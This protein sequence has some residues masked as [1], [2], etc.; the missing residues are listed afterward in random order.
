ML[1]VTEHPLDDRERVVIAVNLSPM[2]LRETLRLQ[3]GW[4]L[5][6]SFRGDMA[7]GVLSLPANDA[8]VF[9]VLR[10]GSTEG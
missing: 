5:G 9:T 7:S 6:R 8:A 1:A 3:P 2:S 10:H 4:A